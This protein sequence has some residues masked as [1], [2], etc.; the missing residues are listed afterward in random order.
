MGI[1]DLTWKAWAISRQR[2]IYVENLNHVD[3]V[4]VCSFNVS[5]AQM[6]LRS[7]WNQMPGWHTSEHTGTH[8]KHVC[9]GDVFMLGMYGEHG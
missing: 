3:K 8:L 9:A 7:A 6:V 2:P 5:K 4:K 1:L